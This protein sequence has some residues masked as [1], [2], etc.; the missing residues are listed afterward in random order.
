MTRVL[1]S[2]DHTMLHLVPRRLLREGDALVVSAGGWRRDVLRQTVIDARALF[3][4]EL[5]RQAGDNEPSPSLVYVSCSPRRRPEFMG[6]PIDSA[7]VDWEPS[8]VPGWPDDYDE[9]VRLMQRTISGRDGLLVSGVPLLR[10]MGW[11]YGSLSMLHSPC[12]VQTQGF[13][14]RSPLRRLADKL[15]GN[16]QFE[17]ACRE[18][19]IQHTGSSSRLA[20]AGIQV[21][22]GD[23]GSAVSPSTAAAATRVAGGYGLA[24]VYVF[25]KK[26]SAIRNY[27][28]R[29][30]RAPA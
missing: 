19:Y 18:L 3:D 17:L 25:G 23:V 10:D 5:K 28:E 1:I 12:I 7:L 2:V 14:Y 21:A 16:N 9:N 6:W 4:A 8:T 29:I 22:F 15:T 13:I 24:Q 30:G 11:D 20:H 27:L 26:P